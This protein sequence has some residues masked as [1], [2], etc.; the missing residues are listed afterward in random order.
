MG[1]PAAVERFLGDTEIVPAG[2]MAMGGAYEGARAFD[3]ALATWQP[4][5]QGVDAD[6]LPDKN[7]SDARVNDLL[8]NDGYV[9]SGQALHRDLVVGSMFLLNAKP[10]GRVL[11]P[12]FDEMW[13]KEFQ[14]EVEA[15]F[16]LWAESPEC[17]VD[18]SRKNTLT[19]LVRLV[20]GVYLAA[21]ETLATVEWLR[22]KGRMFNTAIQMVELARLSN[23]TQVPFAT[24]KV[25]GGVRM[26]KFGAPE[27]YYIRLAAPGV[28]FFQD[29]RMAEQHKYVPIRKPWGRIQVIHLLEQMRPEQTRGISQM[30]AALREMRITKRFRDVTL[31]NAVVNASYA[32]SIESDLPPEAV[33][34]AMGAGNV[35]QQIVNYATGYLSAIS[36]YSDSSRNIHLDGV[37]IPHLF[38]GTKLNLRPVGKPGGIG[39]DFEASLLRHIAASLG[40]TFEQLSKDF[41]KTN[42][43]S[44]RAG[45][46]ETWRYMQSRKRLIAD[47]FATHVYRLWFEEA[48]NKG[49][50]TSLPRNAPNFYDGMNADAYCDCEWIGAGRQ[51]IDP[52]K[53]VQANILKLKNRLTT[54][55][56]V[57]GESGED[58]RKVFAQLQREQKILEELDL[59][60]EEDNA[61]NAASG[62]P[63]DPS[64][65]DPD[66]E[67][68]D[69]DG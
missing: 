68:D 36:Q 14:A 18:A 26:N 17:W 38:P 43:S 62:T 7:L 49:E 20:V 67:E 42:Y 3:R 25:K 4:P 44:I 12:S 24:E 21:G 28:S 2:E 10:N 13:E 47:R 50:V 66:D 1:Y 45:L 40:V 39:Q 27:G 55:E 29:F 11:G 58:W 5:I 9:A 52:V 64:T 60:P 8:R 32:A 16:T 37:K 56:R 63:S 69:D 22:D 65:P 35:S 15:K 51:E 34:Q 19:G 6:V 54:W 48:L 23:P 41:S 61:I 30:I 46:A 57:I 53:E 33:Y 31:Q 59:L